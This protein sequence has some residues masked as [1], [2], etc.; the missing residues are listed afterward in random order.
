MDNKEERETIR[1][2][3]ERWERE[4]LK[5]ALEKAP[6]RQPGFETPSQ[7]PLHRLYTPEDVGPE[8]RDKLGF[9]GAYPFTRGVQ[10]T[11][12]RGRLWTMRQYAGFGS[13]A[14]ANQRFKYL[15]QQGQTGL[16]VAFD[17]PTQ[18]GYDSDDPAARGEVG[19][20]G[21]AISSLADME[22]L[23]D[24]IPLDRV[25]TS[26]TINAT[27]A[28]LLALYVAVGEKQGV[29]RAA[30]SGTVQ[31]D[32]LKEYIARGT[33]IYPPRPSLRIVTDIF[34]FCAAE[35]PRWNSISISGYHVRE[36]GC[37]AVQEVA[38]T[39]GNGIA[40]VE[41][42]LR[43]G[44]DVDAFAAQLAFFF[45]A[46]NTFF[47]EI[48]KYRAARRLWACL[49]RERFKA[50]DPRSWM[51][52][53]HTQTSGVSLTAQQPEN[54]VVRVA[55]QALAAVLG[56]TQSLHTNSR[57]EA[58]ALPTE[59]AVRIALRTQ[60]ILGHETG[61]ADVIDPLGGSYLVEALTDRVEAEARAY[62]ERIDGMGGMLRAIETGFVQKEI[63]DAA[64]REQQAI[65][66]RRRIVVGVNAFTGDENT[67]IPLFQVDPRIERDQVERLQRVRAGRD[68]AAAERALG[69]LAD[70]ARGGDNLMPAILEAVRAYAT[71]GEI[72]YRLR[73]VFGEHEES[74]V[75]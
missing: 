5:R 69:R 70:A 49:M 27:A 21:V 29:P 7:I 71:L 75:L 54:N 66:E 68:G 72:C 4:T 9:P 6:E 61:V 19:K 40:Y 15:L 13:A 24:G 58:L 8:Y 64:Y 59:E 28:L 44:L 57:D 31:N 12:Y 46:H 73:D 42:A 14:E 32:I 38:F 67:S 52:R 30:L 51:L 50:K 25:S 20:V 26:M 11:M 74:V 65:E 60:Q 63:Q 35:M 1:A 43:R 16:S 45:N 56:G 3:R 39:L 17:L 23:L 36:A 22:A 48:A 10:P 47:E 55:Y 37:T 34:A 53:F 62:L 33:Y 2:E 18:M 41:A